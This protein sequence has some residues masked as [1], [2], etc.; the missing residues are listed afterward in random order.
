MD[1]PC[2]RQYL[3]PLLGEQG[4]PRIVLDEKG[5]PGRRTEIMQEIPD[6]FPDDTP[7][8]FPASIGS[9]LYSRAE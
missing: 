2:L 9:M 3:R 1:E 7:E 8:F 6:I 5:T 4:V